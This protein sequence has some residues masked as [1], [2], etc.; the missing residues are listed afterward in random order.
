VAKNP[1]H[2][3]EFMTLMDRLAEIRQ[4]QGKDPL[5][6]P[7]KT[8]VAPGVSPLGPPLGEARQPVDKDLPADWLDPEIDLGQE[9][10]YMQQAKAPSSPLIPRATAPP[11]IP[12]VPNLL[13]SDRT[14]A[15]KGRIVNLSEADEASIRQVVLVAIR[16]EVD[17]DL[18]S[19]APKRSRR[20]RLSSTGLPAAP[21]PDAAPVAPRRRGR[22]RGSL[23]KPTA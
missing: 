2:V 19:V 23:L 10:A 21:G 15:W 6:D 1:N 16:R 7:T 20:P 12:S 3:E 11:P 22:P 9:P 13:V 14:A 8:P 18:A 5:P 17:A 4:M